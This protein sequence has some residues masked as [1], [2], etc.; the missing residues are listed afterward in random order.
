MKSTFF[1][2]MNFFFLCISAWS[3]VSRCFHLWIQAQGLNVVGKK[4]LVKL[5]SWNRDVH[6]RRRVVS[7]SLAKIIY[8][9]VKYSQVWGRHF[10][11]G[12]CFRGNPFLSLSSS[13]QSTFRTPTMV[14]FSTLPFNPDYINRLLSII[15]RACSSSVP[16]PCK[17]LFSALVSASVWAKRPGCFLPLHQ[18]LFLPPPCSSPSLSA[19]LPLALSFPSLPHARLSSPPLIISPTS[20]LLQSI[21]H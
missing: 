3:G 20:H 14:N 2:I 19:S 21:G 15:H 18:K 6:V 16:A 17:D 5:N 1:S 11:E 7:A 12:I 13:I 4:C 9:N 8:A 10:A